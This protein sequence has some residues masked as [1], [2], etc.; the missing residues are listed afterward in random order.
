MFASV[1]AMTCAIVAAGCSSTTRVT[2]PV[3]PR[4]DLA[5]FQTIGLVTFASNA[6]IADVRFSPSAPS[7]SAVA[8]TGALESMAAA[9]RMDPTA[10]ARKAIGRCMDV[11][12]G[13]PD[14][15]R[16]HPVHEAQEIPQGGHEF[17]RSAAFA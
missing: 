17:A 9:M 7:P 16:C 5:Q 4:V 10:V 3:P 13:E 12:F 15:A 6:L 1:A 11:P 14:R 8:I 2:V